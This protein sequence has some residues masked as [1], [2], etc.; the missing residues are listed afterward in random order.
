MVRPDSEA[1]GCRRLGKPLA[2][3][4]AFVFEPG[5]AGRFGDGMEKIEVEARIAEIKERGPSYVAW[6][7]WQR[8]QAEIDL[9]RDVAFLNVTHA[10]QG[11]CTDETGMT[12]RAHGCP[13]VPDSGA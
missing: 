7:E 2:E 4:V 11:D 10:Y 1:R 9:M 5:S 6:H 13:A 12:R 3:Q 8:Q